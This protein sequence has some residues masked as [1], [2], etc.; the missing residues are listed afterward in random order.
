M[1]HAY[2]LKD[3][4]VDDFERETFN[5]A[6]SLGER[7]L[8]HLGVHP[9][10]ARRSA[11]IFQRYDTSVVQKLHSIYKQRNEWVLGA[12]SAREELQKLFETDEKNLEHGEADA[13][14]VVK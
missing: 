6:L 10:T 12:R 5:A 7:T 2:Q 8:V 9:H 11:K 13:A 1:I 4:G 14:W 3:L